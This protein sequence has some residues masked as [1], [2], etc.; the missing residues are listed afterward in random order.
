MSRTTTNWRDRG[1]CLNESPELSFPIGTKG[2]AALQLTQA[3]QVCSACVVCNDC[4]QWALDLNVDQGA[5]GGLSE[6]ER[7]A[8]KRRSARQPLPNT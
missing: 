7:T 5:W 3:K 1:A 8:L 6:D 2:P 4:L